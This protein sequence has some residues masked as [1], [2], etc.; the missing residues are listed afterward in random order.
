M[1]KF[2]TGGERAYR[3]ALDEE[4]KENR[5]SLEARLSAATDVQEQHRLTTELASMDEEYK[6]KRRAVKRSF[7]GT[8]GA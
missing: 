1:F 5:K 6:K 8:R 3:S 7:F 4:Y 2:W